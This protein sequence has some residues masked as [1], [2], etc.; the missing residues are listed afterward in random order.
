M[1]GDQP[2]KRQEPLNDTYPSHSSNLGLK[3]RANPEVCIV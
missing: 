3:D 1:V 2:F